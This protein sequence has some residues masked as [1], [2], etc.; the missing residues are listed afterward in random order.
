[1]P[2]VQSAWC[3]DNDPPPPDTSA[4]L[5]PSPR[6]IEPKTVKKFNICAN[7]LLTG[8]LWKKKKMEDD[9]HSASAE[10][11][12]NTEFVL[13]AFGRLRNERLS[14]KDFGRLKFTLQKPVVSCRSIGPAVASGR[15]GEIALVTPVH[16]SALYQRSAVGPYEEE[17]GGECD[18]G[19]GRESERAGEGGANA[20]ACHINHRGSG[21]IRS[22]SASLRAET[23][24]RRRKERPNEQQ[25]VI[26][27]GAAERR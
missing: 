2:A 18:S 8:K 6:V 10:G 17:K 15:R 11:R 22:V 21:E 19:G 9:F 23:G 14:G 5:I 26:N 12:N 25:V 20:S 13:K 1:M 7:G 4:A 24:G 16:I 27:A 3:L